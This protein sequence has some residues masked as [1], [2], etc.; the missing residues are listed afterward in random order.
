[1][2]EGKKI[3]VDVIW[4]LRMNGNKPPFPCMTSWYAQ[5]RLYLLFKE[6]KGNC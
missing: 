1:V 5:G 2:S 4:A 6:Q 3:K